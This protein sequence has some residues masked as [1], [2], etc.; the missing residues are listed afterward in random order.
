MDVTRD[1]VATLAHDDGGRAVPALDGKR[2]DDPITLPRPSSKARGLRFEVERTPGNDLESP[3]RRDG[4]YSSDPNRHRHA[5]SPL[6]G[7]EHDDLFKAGCVDLD[8]I[9]TGRRRIDVQ[10]VFRTGVEDRQV[11]RPRPGTGLSAG[12]RRYLRSFR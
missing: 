3:D 12:G 8:G 1:R 4:A 2:D 9:A 6:T 11:E 10:R 7:L 5:L